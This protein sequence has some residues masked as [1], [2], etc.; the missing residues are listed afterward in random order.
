M[1]TIG[2]ENLPLT[3]D[4]TYQ[5]YTPPTFPSTTFNIVGDSS[6]ASPVTTINGNSGQVVGPTITITGGSTGYEFQG[7][8]GTLSLVVGNA[9]TVRSSISA[10]KS[11]SNSDI[12]DFTGL[13]GNTGWTNWTGT[14][15]KT[16]HA[17][18]PATVA[19]VTYD[20]TQMQDLMD[21]MQQQTEAFFALLTTLFAWG[22]IET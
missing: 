21:K 17:T 8:S 15:D 13:T 12:S 19:A 2:D 7:S 18:Y 9:A 1:A 6:G 4:F 20:Q 16:S 11:G 3:S 5:Q 10:A 14:Q 22:G